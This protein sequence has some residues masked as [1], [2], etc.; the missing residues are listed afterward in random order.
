MDIPRPDR[1][2]QKRNQRIMYAGG[3]AIAL[4]LATIGISRLKPAAPLVER[5]SVWVDTVKRGPMV[6]QVRGLGTLVPEDIQWIA[7]RTEGRVE[8]IVARPGK[9]VEP[10]SVLC[11]LSNP[12]LTQEAADAELNEKAAE[13]K[14]ASLR[15]QL[16]G[17]IL[18]KRAENAK[19]RSDLEQAELQLAVNERLA[20]NGLVSDLDLKLN[21]VRAAD[22]RAR[23][24]IDIQR[25]KFSEESLRPQLAVQEADVARLKAASELK[26]SQ[27]SALQVRAGMSGVLQL[28]PVEVGQRVTVGL[29]LA[30]VADPSKLKAEVRI[31]ETQAKDIQIGQTASV[32]TRNGVVAGQVIRVDPAVTNGT[33]KVDISLT[34]DMPKGARPDLSVEGVVELERLA[35]VI[36]VGR[37]AYGQERGKVGLFKLSE[38]GSEAS[39]V[40][41]DLGR[42]SVN[43]VEIVAGLQPGDKVILSDMTNWDAH[44]RVRLN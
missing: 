17:Q 40:T 38:N 44:D 23:F 24:E 41:V 4:V 2:R 5:S 7:A 6:R 9:A 37:P 35:D 10:D 27:V 36:Y 25:L 42:S 11:I 30:R 20:K 43:T 31:A 29:N 16:E 15:V 18:D 22:L 26:R 34:G 28:L 12:E 8:K 32:D 39:R 1:S 13:A 19:L 33:V 3:A 14:L 21:R